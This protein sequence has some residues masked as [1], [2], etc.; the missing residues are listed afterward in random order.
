MKQTHF[1]GK[2][3]DIFCYI[4]LCN[5][6]AVKSLAKNGT[7]ASKLTQFLNVMIAFNAEN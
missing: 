2:I 6:Q 4:N 7:E 5:G 1:F 3:S